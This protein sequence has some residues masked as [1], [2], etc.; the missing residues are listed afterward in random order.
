MSIEERDVPEGEE[1]T[2]DTI[3]RVMDYDQLSNVYG[4]V[5]FE[6]NLGKNDGFGKVSLADHIIR[7]AKIRD[8]AIGKI[9]IGPESSV[10]EV[11]KE[12]GNRMMMDLPKIKFKGRKVTVKVVQD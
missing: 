10:V 4:M 9:E 3:R 6:I 1:G 5:K 7:S 8:F 12:Y 11:H 2:K